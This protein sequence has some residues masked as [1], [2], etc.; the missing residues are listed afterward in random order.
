MHLCSKFPSPQVDFSHGNVHPIELPACLDFVNFETPKEKG[1]SDSSIRW[2][3][4]NRGNLVF[5]SLNVANEWK[6]FFYSF[7]LDES[8]V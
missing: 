1:P 8:M 5:V 7:G 3:P 2:I 4:L 6:G